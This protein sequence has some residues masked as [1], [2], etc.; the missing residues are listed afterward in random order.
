MRAVSVWRL[1]AVSIDVPKLSG[2]ESVRVPFFLV[3]IKN[4]ALRVWEG[5]VGRGV[6]ELCL[7]TTVWQM[8]R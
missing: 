8:R 4:G 1:S 3:R 5:Q 7:G 2:A 6:T